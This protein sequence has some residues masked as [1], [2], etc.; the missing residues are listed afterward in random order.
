MKKFLSSVALASLL[1]ATAAP[2]TELPDVDPAIWLVED[3][4]TRIYL[5]GTVHLLDGKK[6]WF[7]DEVKAAYDASDEVYFEIVPPEPAVAQQKTMA[8]A[9]DP[10]GP[11]L[12]SRL[13]K[14]HQ[15]VL[16]AQLAAMGA[17]ANAFDRFD[18]WFAAVLLAQLA[19]QKAGFNPEKGAES[20]LRAAAAKDGKKLGQLED[21]EWQLGLFD[22]LPDDLQLALLTETLDQVD[23]TD[24]MIAKMMA[25]WET[26][27]TEALAALMNEAMRAQ[28]E[29]AKIL[30]ADRNENWAK[31]IDERMD[32]PGTVFLAVGAGHL[33]GPDSVQ[34]KLKTRGI[35]T[36]RLTD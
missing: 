27:D 22:T 1:A 15:A 16:A 36:K 8:I 20:V 14:E 26:G 30:L 18:A 3:A 11:P 10:D 33:G 23:E 19:Y 31:W 12:S 35:A 9:M 25:S 7:N 17:P 13:S 6:A 34:Q 2:A 21:F 24:E 4:D 32:Q 28:P 5:F 29:I